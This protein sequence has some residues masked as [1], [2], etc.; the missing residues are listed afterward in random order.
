[1]DGDLCKGMSLRSII[2]IIQ[3]NGMRLRSNE[4]ISND[5]VRLHGL[6]RAAE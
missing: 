1:M 2:E 6:D 4:I 5:T 3:K